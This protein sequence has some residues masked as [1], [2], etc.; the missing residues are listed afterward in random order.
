MHPYRGIVRTYR[1]SDGPST[2][3]DDQKTLTCQSA[4][5]NDAPRNPLQ[6]PIT[7]NLAQTRPYS[8]LHLRL[9]IRLR[10]HLRLRLRVRAEYA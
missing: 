7:W 1:R 10:L 5:T 6:G 8:M 3:T 2:R 4:D 9:H